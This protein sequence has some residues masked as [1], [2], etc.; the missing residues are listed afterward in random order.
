M[1][2][3]NKIIAKIG[4]DKV[5]HFAFGGWLACFGSTWYYA[6]LIGFTIG[7][8]KELFDRYIRK[9]T[10]DYIDWVATFFG[11]ILT[12]IVLLLGG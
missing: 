2:I 5:L 12:A 11:S 4:I 8:A 3:Q 6:L 7:L 9:S 1:D 10:F